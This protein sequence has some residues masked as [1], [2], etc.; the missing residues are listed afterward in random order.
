[1]NIGYA[2]S[3]TVELLPRALRRFQESN[4]GVKVTLHDLSTE[5]MLAGLLEQRLH[6]AMMLRPSAKIRR[7]LVFESLARYAVCVAVH[8][9]HPLASAK[10]IGLGKLVAER[11]IVYTRQ[12]YPEYHDWLADLFRPLGAMPPIGEE[13]DS[14]TSLIASIEAGRGVA[15]VPECLACL[16]GP[17]LKLRPLAVKLEPFDVGLTRCSGTPG[18]LVARFVEAART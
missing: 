6:L 1:L 2:P 15:I 10:K 14:V 16:A 4:P 12:D 18:D 5:A 13:H 17:R 3:L 11:L 7:G 8:P 9:S